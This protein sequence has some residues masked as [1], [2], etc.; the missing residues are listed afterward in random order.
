MRAIGFAL[1]LGLLAAVPTMAQP[2]ADQKRLLEEQCV[3][4]ANVTAAAAEAACTSLLAGSDPRLNRP[5]VLL[6]RGL[7]RIALSR[8]ADATADSEAV[9][10]T[11]GVDAAVKADAYVSLG[12]IRSSNND[13][14]GAK[15]A[16]DNAV[17]TRAGFATY[18]WRAAFAIDDGRLQDAVADLNRAL[19][20]ELRA[21][22]D[23]RTL[24]L[25]L[26]G[27]AFRG[28]KELDRALADYDAALGEKPDNVQAIYERAHVLSELGRL[29]QARDGYDRVLL[30]DP[31]YPNAANAA[32][33]IRAARL[34]TD[35]ARARALCDDAVKRAPEAWGAWDSVGMVA[36]QEKRWQDAWDAYDKA[37]RGQ[38][39][40]GKE[41]YASA[42][43]GR[44][45]AARRLG[46]NA[47]G[48]ADIAAAIAADAKVA[49]DY[50]GY[51][52]TP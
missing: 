24:I 15:A 22:A 45:I 28:L 43:F 14:A 27:V 5:N 42:L 47:E 29:T 35:L 17:A 9:L 1:G 30:I 12:R 25:R 52:Q 41:D 37:A 19:A 16:F 44:G 26:R 31:A 20:P 36:L 33:W 46:R 49:T 10:A 23:A 40:A 8:W 4:E 51:G 13:K 50:A 6:Q 18:F 3:G 34:R 7:H 21:S 48:D 2:A 32:C 38:K 39:A 11:P